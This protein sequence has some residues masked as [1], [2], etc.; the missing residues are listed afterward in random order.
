MK[1]LKS[2]L[3]TVMILTI[4]T[5]AIGCSK[6]S[7]N[8][9]DPGNIVQAQATLTLNG[10]GYVNKS[11]TLSNGI[12]EFSLSDTV[13]AIQFSGIV[14]NDSLYFAIIFKG[15]QTGTINWNDDNGALLLKNAS[16]F[17][18]GASQ[19][20]TTISSYGAISGKIEGNI[21]GKLI[22]QISQAEL[23]ISGSFSAVRIPDV[24]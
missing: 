7:D 17:Y 6:K 2:P 19:G 12:A 18:I 9:V 20:T 4:L 1:K 11:V 23:N 5:L 3:F 16:S 14:D 22:E 10:A 24:Q 8:P 15:N 21:N 13:T